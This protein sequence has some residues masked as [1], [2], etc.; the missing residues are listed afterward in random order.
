MRSMTVMLVTTGVLTVAGCGAQ[1]PSPVP[2]GTG[3]PAT[4][5]SPS[6]APVLPT[7]P[8]PSAGAPPSSGPPRT[9]EG[10]PTAPPATG[11]VPGGLPYGQRRA[12]G[13]VEKS[14]NCTLL[15]V[16]ARHWELTGT[17]ADRLADGSTVTVT[18]QVTTATGCADDVVR[19]LIVHAVSPG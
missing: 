6:P 2:T 1:P 8:P 19:T 3:P 9:E 15:R 16:G 17:L 7:D 18:G 11:E 12:T 5:P 13:V 4:A 14:G 10:V